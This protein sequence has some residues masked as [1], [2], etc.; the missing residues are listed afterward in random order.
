MGPHQ[1]LAEPEQTVTSITGLEF[2]AS[3]NAPPRAIEGR[4]HWRLTWQRLLG[5]KVALASAAVIVVM[6]GLAIA[7][8]A[9]AALTGHGPAQQFP[10]TGISATGAPA[11]PGRAFWLGADELGRD[12]FVRILYG[13][14][15]S[16]FVGVVTTAIGTVAGVALGLMAGYFGGWIDMVL[17]RLTDAVL[18]FPYIVLGLALA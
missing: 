9:F 14:R 4:S 12:L 6:A 16:L 1:H 17:S 7:A 18:A 2:Q 5:D 15:I 11:G 13:A 8:P 10:N 3:L